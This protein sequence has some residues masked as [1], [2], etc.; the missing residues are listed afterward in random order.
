MM[1]MERRWRTAI[2][3]SVLLHALVLAAAGA[4]WQWE[5]VR[6]QKTKEPVYLEVTMAD[7]FAPVRPG[8]EIPGPAGGDGKTAGGG[9]TPAGEAGGTTE[10]TAGK[11]PIPQVSQGF[12]AVVNPDAAAALGADTILGEGRGESDKGTGGGVGGGKGSG[13]GGTGGT[14]GGTGG[15]HG[16]GYGTGYGPG[17]G[18]GTG[19]GPGT[20]SGTTRGPRI[21][22][23]EKPEYPGNARGKGWEGTVRL[24][25]LVNTAGRVEEVRIMSSSGYDELD[26]AARQAVQEW[27][28][29]PALQNGSPVAAWATLPVVFDLR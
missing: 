27:R 1:G 23:G 26:Q 22:E 21:V 24:Q 13:G 3:G 11:L 2:G 14:G 25:I 8:E 10:K 7:L 5:S 29:S 9:G 6:E 12:S 15:G 17:T 18:R 20:G 19:Y 16:T 28:F 4:L